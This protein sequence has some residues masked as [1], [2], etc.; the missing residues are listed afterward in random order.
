MRGHQPRG[1]GGTAPGGR[2]AAVTHVPR[3][4]T[5]PHGSSGH[6]LADRWPASR[7][8]LGAPANPPLRPARRAARARRWPPGRPPTDQGCRAATR[9]RAVPGPG[10]AGR[11]C[12]GQVGGGRGG[13][14]L[15]GP[16]RAPGIVFSVQD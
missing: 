5:R 10:N 7:G 8:S 12:A 14:P 11:G 13:P 9:R 3:R 2:A 4:R 6:R 16:A 15:H 1:D